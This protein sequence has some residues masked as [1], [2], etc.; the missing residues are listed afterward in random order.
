MSSF[1]VLLLNFSFRFVVALM[2]VLLL[3]GFLLSIERLFFLH[4]TRTRPDALLN[5]IQNLLQKGR[6]QEALTICEQTP[7]ALARIFKRLL[8][9]KGAPRE[10]LENEYLL[11]AEWEIQ[12]LE[13][14]FSSIAMIAKML[15]ILGFIGTSIALLQG[16]G[17]LFAWKP[18]ATISEFSVFFVNAFSVT[19]LGFLGNILLNLFYHFLY[20]RL[21]SLT[22]DIEMYA[23]E[24]FCFLAPFSASEFNLNSQNEE[25]S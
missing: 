11:Q 3:I 13:K 9:S 20:G 18:Y 7:G 21:R 1:L 15:P 17:N 16:F 22:R 25:V 2:V 24:L 23:R 14:R 5:G 19:L 12:G 10:T 6:F 4:R 8:I